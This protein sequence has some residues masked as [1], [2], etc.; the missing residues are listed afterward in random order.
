VTALPQIPQLDLWRPS[1]TGREGAE[2]GRRE[3]R[4]DERGGDGRGEPQ[5][6]YRQLNLKP[7]LYYKDNRKMAAGK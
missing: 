7:P 5:G 2:R 3:R 1:S 6:Q 4:E